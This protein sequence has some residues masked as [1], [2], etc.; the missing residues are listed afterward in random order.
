MNAKKPSAIAA[1]PMIG[2][3]RPKRRQFRGALLFKVSAVEVIVI[4]VVGL[5]LCVAWLEKELFLCVI[6]D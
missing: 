3:P 2:I 1:N 5:E 4:G 6:L